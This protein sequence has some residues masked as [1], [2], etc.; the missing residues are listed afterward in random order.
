MSNVKISC[1]FQP[2]TKIIQ[3]VSIGTSQDYGIRKITP[4]FLKKIRLTIETT[5]NCIFE[6][7]LILKFRWCYNLQIS[8]CIM[9]NVLKILGVL[10]WYCRCLRMYPN[11]LIF[12]F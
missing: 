9:S 8:S 11:K 1:R 3:I 2:R 12:D 6:I 4:D 5:I 10:L 7:A